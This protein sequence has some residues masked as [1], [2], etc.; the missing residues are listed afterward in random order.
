MIENLHFS[1]LDQILPGW[2]LL[3]L[4]HEITHWSEAATVSL[5]YTQEDV[6]NQHF[7]NLLPDSRDDRENFLVHLQGSNPARFGRQAKP[8]HP[9][10]LTASLPPACGI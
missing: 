1:N 3:N 6:L 2:F 8:L 5:G 4:E 7:I 10:R 9:A